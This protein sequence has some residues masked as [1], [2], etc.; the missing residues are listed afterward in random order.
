MQNHTLEKIHIAV[1]NVFLIHPPLSSF[2]E[3]VGLL[4]NEGV[5]L[6]E[7][8]YSINYGILAEIALTWKRRELVCL[9][10]VSKQIRI[11]P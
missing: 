4:F 10:V 11:F 5:Y 6:G 9:H 3:R 7:G 2:V 8:V 1:E